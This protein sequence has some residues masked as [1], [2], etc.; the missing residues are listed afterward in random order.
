MRKLKGAIIGLGKMGLS[1]ATIVGA[2]PEVNMV[3][4]CDKS[5]LILDAF[6]RTN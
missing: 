2:H 3:S 5:S 1:H 4:V 6:K